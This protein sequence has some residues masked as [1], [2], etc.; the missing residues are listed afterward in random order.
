MGTITSLIVHA[1]LAEDMAPVHRETNRD[2]PEKDV[3]SKPTYKNAKSAPGQK[4]W[5]ATAGC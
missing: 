2:G 4:D 5:Y 3:G 1:D